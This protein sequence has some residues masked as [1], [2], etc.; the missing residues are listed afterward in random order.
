MKAPPS[1]RLNS[2]QIS[3]ANSRIQS[4]SGSNT[5]ALLGGTVSIDSVGRLGG[6]EVLQ[7]CLGVGF[8]GLGTFVP[9]SGA[10]FA[11]LVL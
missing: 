5:R 3:L 4:F 11:V 8:D 9:V 1:N 2:K 6:G 10:D 7:R